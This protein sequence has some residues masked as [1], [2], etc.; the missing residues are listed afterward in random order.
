MNNIVDWQKSDKAINT[1]T[2]KL[3]N[4][5]ITNVYQTT[6]AY[7]INAEVCMTMVKI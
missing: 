6:S 4:N 7:M 1:I 3:L 5:Y 2:L